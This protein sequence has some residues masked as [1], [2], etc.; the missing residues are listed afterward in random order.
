MISSH[1]PD[2]TFKETVYICII[3]SR[4]VQLPTGLISLSCMENMYWGSHVSIKE[5]SSSI[6]LYCIPVVK[7]RC[8]YISYNFVTFPIQSLLPVR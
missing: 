1:D 3:L 7:L 4:G 6:F 2:P 8:N 5:L